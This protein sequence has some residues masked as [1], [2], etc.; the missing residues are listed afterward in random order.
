MI[1]DLKNKKILVIC[2]SP[3]KVSHI[4]DYLRKAGRVKAAAAFFGFIVA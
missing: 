1:E 3:N 2:E 4:R